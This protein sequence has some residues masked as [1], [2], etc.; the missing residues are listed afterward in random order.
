MLS[1]P[2]SLWTSISVPQYLHRLN[3][4]MIGPALVHP[5]VLQGPWTYD[6]PRTMPCPEVCLHLHWFWSPFCPH[7]GFC[8]PSSTSVVVYPLPS[9][10]ILHPSEAFAL[11][12]LSPSVRIFSWNPYAALVLVPRFTFISVPNSF[13]FDLGASFNGCSRLGS[14]SSACFGL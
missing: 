3:E 12:S 6:R 5:W 4:S 2:V 11:V 9:V 14:S 7:F 10:R 1:T 13:C 8:P